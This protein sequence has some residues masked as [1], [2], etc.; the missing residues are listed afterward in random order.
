M[1]RKKLERIDEETARTIGA[2]L[3]FAEAIE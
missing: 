3:R 1:P 2:L